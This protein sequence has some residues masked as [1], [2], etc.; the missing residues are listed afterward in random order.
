LTLTTLEFPVNFEGNLY[1]SG[2]LVAFAARRS[3]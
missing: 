1:C 3:H 2:A